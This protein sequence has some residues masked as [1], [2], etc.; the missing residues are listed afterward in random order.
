M[1]TTMDAMV[2]CPPPERTFVLGLGRVVLAATHVNGLPGIVLSNAKIASAPGESAP[3]DAIDEDNAVLL[4]FT[5]PES[6]HQFYDEL[7]L[8]VKVAQDARD[9]Q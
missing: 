9:A 2:K 3:N 7:K 4:V 1:G 6:C 8:A 5:S